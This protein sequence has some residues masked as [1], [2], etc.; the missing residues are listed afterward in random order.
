MKHSICFTIVLIFTFSFSY[1]AKKTGDSLSREELM[2]ELLGPVD[3][4][5]ELS[6][7]S[8]VV[9][10][11]QANDQRKLKHRLQLFLS[12]YPQSHYADNALY[13]AGRQAMENKNYPEAIKYFQRVITQYPQ[14]NR[15]VTAQ[16]AKAMTYKKMNLSP[17]AKK[18]FGQIK[19]TYPG[20]PEYFRADNELKLIK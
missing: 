4:K 16:F 12:R 19:T 11:Y 7:Y 13:L 10:F 20:S 14:S 5:D 6:L 8:E 17:Q 18:V 2:K 1:A 9:S 15:V 3:A